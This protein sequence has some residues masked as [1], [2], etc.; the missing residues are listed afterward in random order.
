MGKRKEAYNL[1]RTDRRKL[2]NLIDLNRSM[3]RNFT[4]QL[5]RIPLLVSRSQT[6][7]KQLVDVLKKE[8]GLTYAEAYV[9]LELAYTQI[10]EESNFVQFQ[11]VD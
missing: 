9:A 2:L 1:E 5:M 8:K 6:V 10:K 11:E 4:H 7:A 3:R